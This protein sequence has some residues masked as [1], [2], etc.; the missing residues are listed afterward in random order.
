MLLSKHIME[1]MRCIMQI[2]SEIER[3]T[4]EERESY[5]REALR[6]KFDCENCGM[7]RIFRGKTPEVVYADYIAGKRSFAEITMKYRR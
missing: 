6:C 3:S 1:L 4:P 5:I 7:C 2:L